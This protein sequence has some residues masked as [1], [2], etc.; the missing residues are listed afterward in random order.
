MGRMLA[1]A[2]SVIMTMYANTLM[3]CSIRIFFFLLST[4]FPSF[5]GGNRPFG[6]GLQL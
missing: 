4:V 3:T 5:M 6:G 2:L 1:N